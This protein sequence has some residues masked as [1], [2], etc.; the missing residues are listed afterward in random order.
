MLK[1]GI[2]GVVMFLEKWVRRKICKFVGC[3]QKGL[4]MG[5]HGV[6]A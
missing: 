6:V 1:K 5:I 3:L 2:R 4:R